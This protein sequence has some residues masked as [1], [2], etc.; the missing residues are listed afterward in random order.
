MAIKLADDRKVM[1]AAGFTMMAIAQAVLYSTIFE[2]FGGVTE[3]AKE[4]ASHIQIA[5]TM[6]YLPALILISTY[7]EFPRWLNWSA[8]I[9][10][11]PFIIGCAFFIAGYKNDQFSEAIGNISY[12]AFNFLQIFWG[13]FV[14]KRRHE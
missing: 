3:E 5:G 4:S 2:A 8:I 11:V 1:S 7:A 6:L 14:W 13:I 10:N 9:I 12:T